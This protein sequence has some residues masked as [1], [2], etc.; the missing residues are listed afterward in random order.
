[1]N[2]KAQFFKCTTFSFPILLSISLSILFNFS[3]NYSSV[4]LNLYYAC[5][6]FLASHVNNKWSGYNI[7]HEQ[8]NKNYL[9]LYVS[10]IT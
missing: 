7:F 2:E 9:S 1:M 3:L 10:G 5:F 4:H 6:H 8:N